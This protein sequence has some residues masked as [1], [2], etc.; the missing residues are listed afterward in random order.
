L[1]LTNTDHLV[2]V[3]DNNTWSW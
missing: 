1:T 3:N 2:N